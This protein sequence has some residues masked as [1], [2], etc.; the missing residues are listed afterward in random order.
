MNKL[1]IVVT[2]IEEVPDWRDCPAL[3]L[4]FDR[5]TDRNLFNVWMREQ[6]HRLFQDW[7]DSQT[8]M[9]EKP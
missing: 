5:A 8:F 3:I 7:L 2:R 9:E 1:S 6:G 4:E